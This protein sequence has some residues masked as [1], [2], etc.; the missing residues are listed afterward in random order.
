M[1]SRNRASKPARPAQGDH[2]AG[3]LP[4]FAPAEQRNQTNLCADLMAAG[5]ARHSP[6]SRVMIHSAAALACVAATVATNSAMKTALRQFQATDS[7]INPISAQGKPATMSADRNAVSVMPHRER[8][9]WRSDRRRRSSPINRCT[10]RANNT[11]PSSNETAHVSCQP[12]SILIS[13]NDTDAQIATDKNNIA[14]LIE[15]AWE[16]GSPA[17][18]PRCCRV[19]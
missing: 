15:Y 6:P 12:C 14:N 9:S 11:M 8:E 2:D 17:E 10:S 16:R 1:P 3:R 4:D 13:Q 7:S 5:G 19:D 18:T